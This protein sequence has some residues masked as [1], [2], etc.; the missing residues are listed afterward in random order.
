[1]SKKNEFV[2]DGKCE[3]CFYLGACD[4]KTRR[5]PGCAIALLF[6]GFS[7]A[8]LC[9]IGCLLIWIISSLM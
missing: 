8:F 3:D 6:L 4:E 5:E 7:V 2:C 1:M 9:E